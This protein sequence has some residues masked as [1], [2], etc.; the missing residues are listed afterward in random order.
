MKTKHF[1]SII[2]V[3]V[4]LG[5]MTKSLALNEERNSFDETELSVSTTSAVRSDAVKAD[6]DGLPNLH[7]E[8]CTILKR[9]FRHLSHG[10]G[11]N[12]SVKGNVIGCGGQEDQGRELP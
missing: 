4:F 7:P 6:F 8:L 10:H 11:Y 3:I 9:Q 5:S 1:F 2:L 12:G